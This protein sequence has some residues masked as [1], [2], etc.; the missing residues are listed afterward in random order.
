MTALTY[1]Y[2]SIVC[3][4]FFISLYNLV[5][6][7]H[8]K[9]KITPCCSYKDPSKFSDAQKLQMQIYSETTFKEQGCTLLFTQTI[10]YKGIINSNMTF[11]SSSSSSSNSTNT[12]HFNNLTSNIYQS[13]IS[14]YT[15]PY[16]IGILYAICGSLYFLEFLGVYRY[17]GY[18]TRY[19]KKYSCFQRI[20]G[21]Y[22]KSTPLIVTII[23][24]VILILIGHQWYFL[25]EDCRN[26]RYTIFY[27]NLSSNLDAVWLE[28]Y[29]ILIVTSGIWFAMH[30]IWPVIKQK[31]H[32][33]SFIYVPNDP[34]RN[35]LIKYLFI[36]YGP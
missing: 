13:S 18:L 33:D 14:I 9:T 32:I 10:T 1:Y 19:Y 22:L 21:I 28:F 8:Y 35:L 31:I 34:Y 5:E 30:F 3:I 29:I 27:N 4:F 2:G 12:T 16:V 11:G 7:D 36:K 15:I 20:I 17:S 23:H 24:Y 25:E 6:I 26:T